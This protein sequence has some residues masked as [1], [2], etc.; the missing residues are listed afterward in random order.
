MSSDDLS[1]L[2]NLAS[3]TCESSES[4][5]QIHIL[6]YNTLPIIYIIKSIQLRNPANSNIDL[7]DLIPSRVIN[8]PRLWQSKNILEFPNSIRSRFSINT[9]HSNRRQRRI[10]LSN[11]IQLLLYLPNLI[12]AASNRQIISR[13][14]RRNS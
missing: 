4:A 13:P 5:F 11:P 6:F 2:S 1:S 14:G 10:I 9:I 12:P 7:T 3:I 8:N